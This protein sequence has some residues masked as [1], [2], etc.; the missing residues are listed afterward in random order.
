MHRETSLVWD[1]A[2]RKIIRKL[3]PLTTRYSRTRMNAAIDSGGKYLA[4][5]CG[6]KYVRVWDVATGQE[7]FAPE[8]RHSGWLPATCYSPS[9]SLIATGDSNGL[10]RIWDATTGQ[11][12][13]SLTGSDGT[14]RGLAFTK[15]DSRLFVGGEGYEPEKLAFIGRL[16]AFHVSDGTQ[17]LERSFPGRVMSIRL[18]HD[19]SSVAVGSGLGDSFG[20]RESDPMVHVCEATSGKTLG[21]WKAGQAKIAALAWSQDNRLLVYAAEDN[22]IRT[23]DVQAGK[24]TAQIDVPHERVQMDKVLPDRLSLAWLLPHRELAVTCTTFGPSIH[25]WDLARGAK[26]WSLA[27]PGSRNMRFALS[28]DERVLASAWMDFEKQQCGLALWEVSTR[29]PLVELA[30]PRE[31]VYSMAFSSD[32]RRIVTGMETGSSLVWDVSAAWQQLSAAD[33]DNK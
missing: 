21:E 28:P 31:Q 24:Q 3:P 6:E 11:I 2:E 7:L 22:T 14:I 19:D 10:V 29:K 20:E 13:K 1:L 30:L 26:S 27:T 8:R 5:H 25:G 33:G 15:D 16:K 4:V 12:V 9:G 23:I 17:A 32:G 18:S